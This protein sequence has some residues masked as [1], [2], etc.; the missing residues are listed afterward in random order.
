MNIRDF[1][2]VP[3]LC[4]C[5]LA[6]SS[7]KLL[8]QSILMDSFG[9]DQGLVGNMV[10]DIIQGPEGK[11][12]VITDKALN[13]F[14]GQSWNSLSEINGVS[15]PNNKYSRLHY[16]EVKEQILVLGYIR[17]KTFKLFSYKNAEWTTIDH[18]FL[19][20]DF[21]VSVF[22]SKK[23]QLCLIA[24]SG[25][26]T[27]YDIDK[28][29]WITTDINDTEVLNA[30]IYDDNFTLYTT[31]GVFSIGLN[32][33]ELIFDSIETPSWI[34]NGVELILNDKV[35]T[36]Q[37]I[38]TYPDK[39]YRTD[40]KSFNI[41]HKRNIEIKSRTNMQSLVQVYQ[42]E[43]DN[44]YI[45]S[46][47]QFFVANESGE[48]EMVYSTDFDNEQWVNRFFVD[49]TNVVWIGS[50]KGLKK[51]DSF[52]LRHYD[53]KNGI[54]K[55]E[56]TAINQFNDGSIFIGLV[57]SYQII[58]NKVFKNFQI[59]K[60]ETP[61]KRI[62]TT[63]QDSKKD[64]IWIAGHNSGLHLISNDLH[65]QTIVDEPNVVSDVLVK[66]DSLFYI[67][68][69]LDIVSSYNNNKDLINILDK[70][71][72]AR[73]IYYDTNLIILTNRG[74]VDANTLE[75][76]FT[77]V[78]D[79]QNMSKSTYTLIEYE[80]GYLVGTLGG[81]YYWNGKNDDDNKLIEINGIPLDMSVYALIIDRYE[82]LW[83]GTNKGVYIISAKFDEVR[84]IN[85]GDGLLSNEINRGA[86]K[87]MVNGDIY[88]GTD[89]G[90]SIYR[91]K[92]DEVNLLPPTAIINHV[93]TKDFIKTNVLYNF[94]I[95]IPNYYDMSSHLIRYRLKGFDNEYKLIERIKLQDIVYM[96]LRD[97]NYQ[98]EVQLKQKNSEWSSAYF[99]S[100][101]AVSQ[102]FING[103]FNYIM[104]FI[105]ASLLT[106]YFTKKYYEKKYEA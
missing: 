85:T 87:E 2:N 22:D 106:G 9:E 18:P 89:K 92:F 78:N 73:R 67:E 10:Y 11:I 21:L 23:Q 25:F 80:N 20:N 27:I 28:D 40:N 61:F 96:N 95:H 5:F 93:I 56:V 102:S 3:L 86:L 4:L 83:L 57:G 66:N 1:R 91:L 36:N 37:S 50:N 99:S 24:K 41:S 43:N 17:D 52:M 97:G 42:T 47:D 88:I 19:R 81:L 53:K 35:Y 16:N 30:G 58:Q 33:S 29:S 39:F 69:Y 8:A 7:N 38:V 101:I 68:N 62:T 105:L 26:L 103:Y 12:W 82:R 75:E 54:E 94:N 46:N 104:C 79:D 60:T 84:V 44:L 77:G 34:A 72:Y 31:K 70:S 98:L 100:E 64:E 51:I 49:N 32:N 63:F 13:N 71:Y 74:I 45:I 6:F 15:F 55:N 76:I 59:N 14:D 65:F 90:L 48:L